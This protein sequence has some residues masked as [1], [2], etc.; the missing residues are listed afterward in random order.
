MVEYILILPIDID[1]VI[2]NYK[3]RMT[4]KINLDNIKIN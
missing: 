2:V 1:F 4:I 3:L